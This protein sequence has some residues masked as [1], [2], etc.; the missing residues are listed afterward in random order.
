MSIV[1]S[2][3]SS[4]DELLLVL[5]GVPEP[6]VGRCA[7][8]PPENKEARR[9]APIVRKRYFATRWNMSDSTPRGA[10]RGPYHTTQVTWRQVRKSPLRPGQA[11]PGLLTCPIGQF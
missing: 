9:K 8:T 3:P 6:G 4:G 11:C 7:K 2:P 1:G 5:F 10:S